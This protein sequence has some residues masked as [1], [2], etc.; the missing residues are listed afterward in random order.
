MAFLDKIL[1]L[2][3]QYSFFRIASVG[4][5]MDDEPWSYNFHSWKEKR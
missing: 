3:T 1:R 4:E 2:L 5:I